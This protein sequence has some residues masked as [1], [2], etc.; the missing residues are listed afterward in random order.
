MP[1][2]GPLGARPA[3]ATTLFETPCSGTADFCQPPLMPSLLN[4]AKLT[5]ICGNFRRMKPASWDACNMQYVQPP[6]KTSRMPC[7]A[8]T[9][10][11]RQANSRSSVSGKNSGSARAFSDKCYRTAVY[12]FSRNL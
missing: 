6:A 2:C 1:A 5:A 7:L 4:H 10:Q 11:R 9:Q 8:Q 12:K 3:M